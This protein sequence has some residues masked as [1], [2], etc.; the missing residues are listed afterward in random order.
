[1]HTTFEASGPNVVLLRKT[2]LFINH[3]YF[4]LVQKLCSLGKAVFLNKINVSS[5]RKMLFGR[6]KKSAHFQPWS[7]LFS[8]DSMPLL[9]VYNDIEQSQ[10]RSDYPRV[11]NWAT[12]INSSC[13]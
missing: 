5:D 7:Q 12:V 10:F 1:M 11:V 6:G 9:N 8:I 4:W 3:L 2:N 13:M